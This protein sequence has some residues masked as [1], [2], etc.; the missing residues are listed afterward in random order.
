MFKIGDKVIIVG[1]E[2][3]VDK[4]GEVVSD[5]FKFSYHEGDVYLVALDFSDE[6]SPIPYYKA[7]LR[8]FTKLGKVLK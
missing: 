5:S 2:Y 1:D 8:L 6:F 7:N 4:T 3:Q